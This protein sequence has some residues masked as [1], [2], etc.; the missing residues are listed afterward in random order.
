MLSPYIFP[1]DFHF[2]FGC[3]CFVPADDLTVS[4]YLQL[5]EHSYC[6]SQAM[7]YTFYSCCIFKYDFIV[8]MVCSIISCGVCFNNVTCVKYVFHSVRHVLYIY[9]YIYI[10]EHCCRMVVVYMQ[11]ILG[12]RTKLYWSLNNLFSSMQ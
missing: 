9:I 10:N 8:C 1:T 5:Y 3:V 11:C 2:T 7:R 6:I 4:I 12:G